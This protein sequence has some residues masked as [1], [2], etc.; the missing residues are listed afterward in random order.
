[1]QAELSRM[2]ERAKFLLESCELEQA[3]ALYSH[4]YSV[5]SANQLSSE[6]LDD[7]AEL[8][9]SLGSLEEAKKLYSQSISW[10]P[11]ENPSKYFA[12]AQMSTG[13][14]SVEL[15]TKGIGLSRDKGQ[16]ACAYSALAEIYMTDL[17]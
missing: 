4:I 2:Q 1:M 11:S 6:F 8:C 15:Y 13:E 10:F 3:L 5:A 14:S 7:Y 17:W 12:L 9:S 16:V